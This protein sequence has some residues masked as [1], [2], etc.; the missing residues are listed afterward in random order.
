MHGLKVIL[1]N[2]LLII[3]SKIMECTVCEA[4]KIRE[5]N[6]C[7]LSLL[8]VACSEDSPGEPPQASTVAV[9]IVFFHKRLHMS[10]VPIG[11]LSGLILI[12][13]HHGSITHHVGEHDGGEFAFRLIEVKFNGVTMRCL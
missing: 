12:F 11:Q 4:M 1:C 5:L 8:L 3:V 7:C 2:R 13:L 10:S 6:S 9:A